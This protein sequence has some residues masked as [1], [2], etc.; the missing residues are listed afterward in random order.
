[1]TAG[2][3]LPRPSVLRDAGLLCLL[4]MASLTRRSMLRFSVI[5]TIIKSIAGAL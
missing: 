1:M 2:G 5:R 3:P 4:A